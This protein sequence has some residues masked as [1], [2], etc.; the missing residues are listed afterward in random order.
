MFRGLAEA[1]SHTDQAELELKDQTTFLDN[2][3]GN[4]AELQRNIVDEERRAQVKCSIYFTELS[5]LP[6]CTFCER[7]GYVGVYKKCSLV[8]MNQRNGREL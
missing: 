7:A 8:K 4:I 2:E 1:K 6:N 5:F 3:K